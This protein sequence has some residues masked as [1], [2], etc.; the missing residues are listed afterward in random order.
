M[1]DVDLD[2]A[3]YFAV[4]RDAFHD[5]P[6]TQFVRQTMELP[7]PGSVRITLHPDR[8]HHHGAG[9]IHGGILAL[10]LDNAGFFASATVTGGFWAA[11]MSS[12]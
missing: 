8:R 7:E 1:P 3:R 11:T 9:S 6:I 4:L 10:L 5:A 12:R 2:P